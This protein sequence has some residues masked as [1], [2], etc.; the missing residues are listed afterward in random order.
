MTEH[1][2]T[3]IPAIVHQKNTTNKFPPPLYLTFLSKRTTEAVGAL[4]VAYLDE[5]V[6]ILQRKLTHSL[7]LGLF[8][9]DNPDTPAPKGTTALQ[10]DVR[11]PAC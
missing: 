6:L 5:T 9:P 1:L 10:K 7:Q 3:L 2:S 4:S 8:R 11:G